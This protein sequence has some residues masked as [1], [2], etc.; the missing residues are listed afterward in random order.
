MNRTTACILVVVLLLGYAAPVQSGELEDGGTKRPKAMDTKGTSSVQWP[1]DRA[2]RSGALKGLFGA[3]S[4]LSALDM[5]STIQAR[6]NGARELNPLLNTDYAQATLTKALFTATTVMG[7]R[8]MAK[9][10]KKAATVTMIV[11][12]IVSAAVVVNNFKNARR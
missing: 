11:I 6:N 2:E 7:V 12:N 3:Y 1:E 10:N 9:K 8:A 5:Y 4:A